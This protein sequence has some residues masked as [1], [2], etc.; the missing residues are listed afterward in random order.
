M[1]LESGAH[2]PLGIVAVGDGCAEHRQHA[3]ARMVD[4]VAA[5]RRDRGIHQRIEAIQQRLHVLGVHAGAQVGVAGDVGEHHGRLAA[6]A[7]GC[8]GR[9]W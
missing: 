5:V 3:V 2:R 8:R 4:H 1:H 9:C 6:F 7:F